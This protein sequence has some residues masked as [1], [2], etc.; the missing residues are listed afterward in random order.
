MWLGTFDT[1]VAAVLA[2]DQ[3]AF[4]AWRRVAGPLALGGGGTWC[5]SSPVLTLKRRKK[6]SIPISSQDLSIALVDNEAWTSERNM[7][8][9]RR[10]DSKGT[11]ERTTRPMSMGDAKV[12]GSNESDGSGVTRQQ[13]IRRRLRREASQQRHHRVG[14]VCGGDD[15]A[16]LGYPTDP[17]DLAL[18]RTKSKWVILVGYYTKLYFLVVGHWVDPN[19]DG[20]FLHDKIEDLIDEVRVADKLSN[21]VVMAFNAKRQHPIIRFNTLEAERESHKN[22]R[23]ADVCITTS[24]TPTYLPAHN[25]KTKDSDGDPYEFELVGGGVAANNRTI[26]AMSLQVKDDDRSPELDGMAAMVA[27]EKTHMKWNNGVEAPPPA[28]IGT[29]TPKQEHKYTA[30]EYGFNPLIDFFSNASIHMV[31]IESHV[32]F[33]AFGCENN[34]LRI[35]KNMDTLIEIGKKLLKGPVA[36]VNVHTGAYEPVPGRPTNEKALEKLARKLIEERRLRQIAR[37]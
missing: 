7:V 19:Y 17:A 13:Q 26:V 24:A 11:T 18:E 37:K 5:S 22:A 29:G 23:L 10:Q 21:I 8:T 36:K 12:R 31:D 16:Y 25:F 3:A 1:T 33:E 15:T 6:Q 9:P 27:M 30:E 32:L 14:T 4:S 2:Y 35:Q 20:K 34:Y 28:S